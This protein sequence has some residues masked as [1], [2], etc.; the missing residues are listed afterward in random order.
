MKSLPPPLTRERSE[1][2]RAW[3]TYLR[4]TKDLQGIAYFD[5]EPWVWAQLQAKLNA[6]ALPRR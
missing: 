2:A 4:E 6:I 3:K 1:I 5:A